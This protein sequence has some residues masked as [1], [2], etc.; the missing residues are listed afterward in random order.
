MDR[1]GLIFD[2]ERSSTVDGPGIRTVIFLK[3]CPLRCVWCQN[4]E[5]QKPFPE[6]RWNPEKC[7]RCL[8]CIEAC[9]DSA[10]SFV[11]NNI[12]TDRNLCKGCGACAKV[13]PTGARQLS[14]EY[15]TVDE[16]FD[17]VKRDYIFYLNT[18]GGVTVTGGEPTSQ[19]EFLIDF[20]KKCREN[21]IHTALD[22]CGFTE[23]KKLDE[24]LKYTDLILYDLKQMDPE[25][26]LLYT[27]V[28][29]K[30]ILE[31]LVKID[32]KGLP[33]WIRVPVVP[34]YTD[35]EDNFNKIAS[36]L[37]GLKNIKRVDLLTYHSYGEQ[38][39]QEMDMDY[40]LKGL[41]PP[42]R[43]KMKRCK[44]ILEMAGIKNVFIS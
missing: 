9:P 42:S 29:N 26:H 5:S 2:I 34:G 17:T 1:R 16:V 32:Q 39:Y 3:G 28:D 35:D 15:M 12:K 41:K 8:S 6:I 4:P 37:K 22:T 21:N 31:N 44:E 20:L 23:W 11:D 14:G 30:K 25:K 24:I 40:T 27:G 33:V 10:I 43:K 18:G 38:K 7:I 19:A 36:F 13:C